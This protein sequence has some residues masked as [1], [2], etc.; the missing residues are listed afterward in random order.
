MIIL[1]EWNTILKALKQYNIDAGLYK[2]K[3]RDKL[4]LTEKNIKAINIFFQLDFA[5][6]H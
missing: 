4:T 2:I 6:K 1:F 3:Q 5:V